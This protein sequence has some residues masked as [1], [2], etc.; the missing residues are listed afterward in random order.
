MI[1]WEDIFIGEKEYGIRILPNVPS[2]TVRYWVAHYY[3]SKILEL[4]FVPDWT[5][6][7]VA[8]RL[9]AYLPFL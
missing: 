3:F 7:T 2:F 6:Q 9:K 8:H 4:N 1:R 5:P